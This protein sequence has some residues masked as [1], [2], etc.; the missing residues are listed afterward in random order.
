MKQPTPEGIRRS[1]IQTAKANLSFIM[2]RTCP[3]LIDVEVTRKTKAIDLP[4]YI[5]GSNGLHNKALAE[6]RLKGDKEPLFS[7]SVF[8]ALSK[9]VE[10]FIAEARAPIAVTAINFQMGEL[11]LVS[12]LLRKYGDT[13]LADLLNDWVKLSSD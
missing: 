12:K 3:D 11:F 1:L 10:E 13:E 7:R 9:R 8:E 2:F 4:M 6:A 5:G